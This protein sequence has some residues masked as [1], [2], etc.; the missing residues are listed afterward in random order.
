MNPLLDNPVYNA[1]CTRDAH[2]GTRQGSV[3]WFDAEVSPFAGFPVGYAPGLAELLGLLPAGRRILHASRTP[4]HAFGGWK[5]VASISGLQFVYGGVTPV[6][7]A[8]ERLVPLS[9]QHATEMVAL[10]ALTR[11][12]PFAIRTIDFGNY[13]GVID[14]GKLVAMAGQRLHLPGYSEISAVCTHPEHL[15]KGYAAALIQ[16]QLSLICATGNTPFLHVRDDNKR[17]I[18][19]YERLGFRVS[20]PMHFYFLEKE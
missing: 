18:A 7:D 4:V 2:L 8:D 19:L 13:F 17:A 1:L 14:G 11:P 12:G 9:A 3:A 15:G 6:D 5:P 20:G 16:R 10:A